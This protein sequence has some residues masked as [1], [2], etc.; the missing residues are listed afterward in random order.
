M[1]ASVTSNK[2]EVIDMFMGCY[3][4]GVTRIVAAA[5]EQNYD[6]KGIIWPSSLS[7]FNAAI[8]EID[9]NKNKNVRSLAQKLYDI[10]QSKKIDVILDDRQVTFGNKFKD[11]ELIGVPNIFIIGKKES[12][13][14]LITFQ[15]RADNKKEIV[16][17][18]DIEKLLEE[19]SI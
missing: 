5:I 16:N 2:S 3:G 17:L 7:P 1:G 19:L 12:E 11:W 18:D 10:M 4:I 9:G 14:Q 6:D 15:R 13:E 8:I